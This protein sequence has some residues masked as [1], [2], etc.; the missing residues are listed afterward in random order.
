M[1]A[2]GYRWIDDF[3]VLADPSTLLEFALPDGR[4]AVVH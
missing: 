1:V 3:S 2:Q 4:L